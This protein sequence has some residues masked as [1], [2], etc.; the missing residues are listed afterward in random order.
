M[1]LKMSKDTKQN[2]IQTE[3]GHVVPEYLTKDK[4]WK[5]VKKIFKDDKGR[6]IELT[7][8]EFSIFESVFRRKYPRLHIMCLTRYGKS[9]SVGLAV[10]LRAATHPERWVL[11]GGK[12]KQAKIIMEVVNSHIFDHPSIANAFTGSSSDKQDIRRHRNKSHVTFNVGEGL[13]GE[14]FIATPNDAL[15]Y[16]SPNVVLDEAALVDDDDY[17][18]ISRMVDDNPHDNFLCKIGNP[19]RR[20]HFLRSHLSPD[21]KNIVIDYHQALEE[22]RATEES[23]EEKRQERFF[24]ILYGCEFPDAQA[25]SDDGYM[26]LVTDQDLANA[27]SRD[28]EPQGKP[29]LALD[30][31]RGGR[32]ENV[33]L[34]RYNNYALV[35]DHNHAYDTMTV[36]GRTVELV[37]EYGVAKDMIFIDD[38]GVG[39]GVTDRLRELEYEPVGVNFGSRPTEENRDEYLNL[40]AEVYA[41]PDGL[42]TWI[43]GGG[44]IEAHDG[45]TDMLE[46]RY[47]K[48]SS[49]KTKME[50]KKDLR[51]RGVESP[52]FADALALTFAPK[53][54]SEY[55][56]PRDTP[57]RRNADQMDVDPYMV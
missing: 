52:D 40:K 31:A 26:Y 3:M 54:T 56:V 12:K 43:K 11:V 23:V 13:I 37:K 57:M 8:G 42:A 4:L 14:I 5:T 41:G 36:V 25:M 44:A 6:P 27:F 35:L 39:G 34:L 15:G 9:M 32:N 1:K 7:E 51:K 20:N 46:V 17:A 29:R 22:G 30:V 48:T 50:S 19:F 28:V 33:W 38:S 53:E 49:G 45:L 24:D 47:T 16:G 21:F 18:L 55:F 2:M 10:L